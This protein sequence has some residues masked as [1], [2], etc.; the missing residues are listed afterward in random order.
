MKYFLVVIIFTSIVFADKL[1]LKNGQTYQG[2]YQG[3]VIEDGKAYFVL[4]ISGTNVNF[5]IDQIE[6][7]EDDEGSVIFITG[8]TDL[9][10][11]IETSNLGK[12]ETRQAVALDKIAKSTHIIAII[13]TV[14]F[15]LSIIS[16]L[17]ISG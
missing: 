15:L 12:V 3:I 10:K 5:I 2:D 7:L 16:I 11:F 8:I 13:T 1:Y 17:L 6:R 4:D 9:D 14:S